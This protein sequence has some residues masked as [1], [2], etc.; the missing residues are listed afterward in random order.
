VARRALVTGATGFVGGLLTGEL[1][2][3]GIGLVTPVDAAIARPLIEGLS[4]LTTVT[5]NSSS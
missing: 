3:G 2:S 5:L 1:A 4:T